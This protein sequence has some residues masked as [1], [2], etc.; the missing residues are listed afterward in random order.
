[1]KRL[2]SIFL[3]VITVISTMLATNVY[4]NDTKTVAPKTVFSNFY[5]Y[6][7]SIKV[8][9]KKKKN[10][11]GYQIQR[12]T[13]YDFKKDSKK[14]TIKGKKKTSKELT[15]LKQKTDYYIR[16]RTFVVKNDKRIYSKW[17]V[18]YCIDTFPTKPINPKGDIRNHL[19]HK[20]KPL[21]PDENN[22]Y[23]VFE[24]YVDNQGGIYNRNGKLINE[25]W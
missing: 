8:E 10:V 16:I 2:L 14:Y 19:T 9:W 17:S 20:I 5:S 21:A 24:G 25:D 3:T 4:A 22:V 15:K 6:K 11:D 23:F 13:T 18:T 7:T 1:M 12:A